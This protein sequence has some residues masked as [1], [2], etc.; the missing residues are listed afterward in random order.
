MSCEIKS[1][2]WITPKVNKNGGKADAIKQ[3]PK[4]KN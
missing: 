1:F 3:Y 4:R 2:Y